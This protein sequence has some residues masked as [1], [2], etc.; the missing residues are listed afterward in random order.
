MLMNKY[1]VLQYM[2]LPCAVGFFFIMAC[3]NKNVSV[4]NEQ[5]SLKDSVKVFA[6]TI[7]KDISHNGPKAWLTYFA[8]TPDF[9]MAS[10]GKLVFPDNKHATDFINDTLSASIKNIS[11]KWNDIRIDSITPSI[12]MMAASFNEVLTDISNKQMPFNGYFTG[13][14]QHTGKG[15]QLRNAHW[16]VEKK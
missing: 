13:V 10:N 12:A 4:N 11:L 3:T 2:R 6:A 1:G 9:F 15:W 7:E 8:T 5:Y 14:V 16:S